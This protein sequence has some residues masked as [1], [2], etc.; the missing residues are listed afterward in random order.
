[1]NATVTVPEAET[2]RPNKYRYPEFAG[3]QGEQLL[4]EIVS[5]I[6]P[7]ALYRTW[8]IHNKAHAP[9]QDCYMS[10][11]KVAEKAVRSERKIKLDL[12][13]L[14]RRGLL[15]TTIVKKVFLQAGT[16]VTCYVTV[17]DFQNLY[18]LAHEFYVW[19]QHPAYIPPQR[20]HAE[21]IKADAVLYKK[22][23]RFHC[24][25][26]ILCDKVPGPTPQVRD[27]EAWYSDPEAHFDF[28]QEAAL[29]VNEHSP[30]R[31]V[32]VYLQEYL[33]EPLQ[34]DSPY[35]ISSTNETNSLSLESDSYD[36]YDRD[37]EIARRD[38]GSFSQKTRRS[39]EVP[40]L[41][42]VLP[43]LPVVPVYTKDEP[44]LITDTP[45]REELLPTQNTTIQTKSPST[46]ED[47]PAKQPSSQEA[48]QWA[49]QQTKAGK[50]KNISTPP[51]S[52]A[53]VTGFVQEIRGI[54]NDQATFSA[55]NTRLLR[56][57]ENAHLTQ[58]QLASCLIQAYHTTYTKQKIKH[59]NNKMPYFFFMFE[60]YVGYMQKG[61]CDL[62]PEQFATS[63]QSDDRLI[64]WA[65][66]QGVAY[67]T[68]QE[69]T[70]PEEPREE[71]VN[72]APPVVEAPQGPVA[73]G[74]ASEKSA[75][76]IGNR[77]ARRLGPEYTCQVLPLAEGGWSFVITNT[78]TTA[79][80]TFTTYSQVEA[81]RQIEPLQ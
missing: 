24:Y 17:K 9:G 19:S 49:Q 41:R 60:T 5:K 76:Y 10:I 47:M 27:Y 57:A 72:V 67:G 8:S 1:M 79:T 45:T 37:Q 48:S 11:S 35:T 78:H 32:K 6:L 36:S 39:T 63:I 15:S 66:E 2:P 28:G 40:S 33:Q 64:L 18:T 59:G 71:P 51:A 29:Q 7:A 42:E 81:R 55:T 77:F 73:G 26:R 68:V 58:E 62:T 20:I 12:E 16:P 44:S 50:Y 43:S 80:E 69:D 75:S 22:L 52:N 34:K 4:D 30:E 38:E 14:R 70:T 13:D 74:F 21:E 61:I 54:F 53:L 3:F 56:L 31:G 25:K 23:R 65:H 46:E